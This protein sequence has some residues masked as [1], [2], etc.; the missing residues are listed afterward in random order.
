M[1]PY[2]NKMGSSKSMLQNW[3]ASHEKA[4]KMSGGPRWL[5]IAMVIVTDVGIITIIWIVGTG[6]DDGTS[7]LTR[8]LRSATSYKHHRKLCILKDTLNSLTNDHGAA[9]VIIKMSQY[10]RSRQH[11]IVC[12][13][14]FHKYFSKARLADSTSIEAMIREVRLAASS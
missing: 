2:T 12:Q 8:T 7:Y 5:S 10:T 4:E 1:E 3:S 13:R 14:R 9:E 6:Q 11:R